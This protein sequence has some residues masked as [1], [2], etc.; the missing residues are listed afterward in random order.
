MCITHFIYNIFLDIKKE[1]FLLSHKKEWNNAICNN[2]DAARDYRAKWRKSKETDK[3]HIIS[4]ICG[5]KNMTRTN[6]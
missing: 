5:M 4:L 1:V 6:L 3:Y 2:M